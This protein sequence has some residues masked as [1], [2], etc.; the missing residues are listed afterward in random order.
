MDAAGR[1]ASAIDGSRRS[2]PRGSRRAA[3]AAVFA[4][5]GSRDDALATVGAR[6]APRRRR[7]RWWQPPGHTSRSGGSTGRA[8]RSSPA[9]SPSPPGRASRSAG[10]SPATARGS[11]SA[12]GLVY[13]AVPRARAAAAGR[14]RPAPAGSPRRWGSWS[15]Q[16]SPGR[17]SGSPCRRSSRT[18]TGSP[19]PRAGRILERA[20]APRRRGLA[21]GLWLARDRQ[22]RARV[23]GRSSATGRPSRCSSP[24]RGPASSA[25]RWCSSLWL[26]LSDRRVVVGGVRARRRA[27]GGRRRQAGPSRVPRSSRTGALRA[28]SG[29]RRRAASLRSSSS[30]PSSSRSRPG[31][32]IRRGSLRSAR[33]AVRTAPFSRRAPLVLVAA[34]RGVVAAVG[35]PVSW[36]VV[37]RSGAASARTTPGRLTDLCANNRPAWWRESVRVA[38]RRPLGGTGAGTFA[39][40]RKRGPRGRE[41]RQR[42]AQRPAAAAR[43]PGVVGLGLGLLLRRR[44]GR[45]HR[46][47]LRLVAPAERP[48]AVALACLVLA[49]GVHALVDYDLDFLAVTA[50]MLVALG[51]CSRSGGRRRTP[52]L[53]ALGLAAVAVGRPPPQRRLRRCCRRSP[54][55]RSSAR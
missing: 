22:I 39:I 42:A 45:R 24:S 28:G 49:Y 14:S 53:G 4:G 21:L 18:A 34:A 16:R 25:G 47:G 33:Q 19:A 2:P 11:G 46:R 3:R 55:A 54:S 41:R 48:P 51:V 30:E 40:A 50:P 36:V 9:P 8:S 10:R 13:L 26:W 20:G 1:P 35:N 52:R 23:G 17:S 7:R 6:G 31:A 44:G 38:A 5:E 43:R 29:R 12:R 27:P 15:R 37:S 32:S